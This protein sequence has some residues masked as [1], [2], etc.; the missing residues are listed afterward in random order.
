MEQSELIYCDVVEKAATIESL[1]EKRDKL[2]KENETKVRTLDELREKGKYLEEQRN[3][4]SSR[5]ETMREKLDKLETSLREDG[6]RTTENMKYFFSLL[7]INFKAEPSPDNL[8][9]LKI[10]FKQDRN[11][12]ATLVYDPK[13]EDYDC[14]LILK[15]LRYSLNNNLCNFSD[16]PSSRASTVPESS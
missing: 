6:A 12:F 15:S 9:D 4:L 3:I 11:Q 14:K 13:T 10:S 16:E 5:N 8:I 7:G 1:W 2:E